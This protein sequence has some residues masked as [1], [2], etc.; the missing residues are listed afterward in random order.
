MTCECAKCVRKLKNVATIFKAKSIEQ[1]KEL[2]DVD[3]PEIFSFCKGNIPTRELNYATDVVLNRKLEE[4]RS[5]RE[6]KSPQ[7]KQESEGKSMDKSMEKSSVKHRTCQLAGQL[8]VPRPPLSHFPREVCKGRDFDA[9]AIGPYF[10]VYSAEGHRS[11]SDVPDAWLDN[12]DNK[13]GTESKLKFNSEMI[14][15]GNVDYCHICKTAGH[16]ILCD[17]CPRGFH[18]DCLRNENQSSPEGDHWECFVCKNEKTETNEHVIDGKESMDLVGPAFLELDITDERALVGLDV[19][20]IIHQMLTNLIHYDFGNVFSKPVDESSVSGYQDIVKCPMDIG[21][22]CSK[23]TNGEFAKLLSEAYTMDDLVTKVLNDIELIWRNCITFNVIGSAVSRMAYVLRRRVKMIYKRSILDRLCDKVITDVKSYAKKFD[24]AWASGL[25]MSFSTEMS[26][27]ST[28][29][30]KLS[31][32]AKL[33]PKSG[34]K[35]MVHATNGKQIAIFDSVCGRV[36]KVYSSVKSASKAV[37]I[38]LKSGYE[39]EWNANASRTDLNLKLIAEKSRNDPNSL[40]FGYRWLFLDDLNDGKVVFWKSICDI[41]EMRYDQCT[42]VFQSV[43]EA[44]SSS[45]LSKTLDV[46]D[47]REKLLRLPRNGDWAEI[48]GLQWRRPSTS[49][50]LRESLECSDYLTETDEGSRLAAEAVINGDNLQSWKN[51]AF[52]KKDLLTNRNLIGFDSIELA[53]RDW[54]QAAM[55]SE[56]F[57]QSEDRSLANFKKFYL[58]GDRNIDGIIWQTVDE[59]NG[60]NQEGKKELT[61]TETIAHRMDLEGGEFSQN[62]LS[63]SKDQEKKDIT[64]ENKESKSRSSINNSSMSSATIWTNTHQQEGLENPFSKIPLEESPNNSRKRK[65]LEGNKIDL[66][67]SKEPRLSVVTVE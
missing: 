34:K 24:E 20:C 11:V 19:L 9:R 18:Q 37:E 62:A 55:I 5:R 41:V 48:D 45:N 27:K 53:H 50:R 51:C 25:T 57:P 58:D 23:L 67:K 36:V 42:L 56:N 35:F 49:N 26:D 31:A 6:E 16:L 47:L 46:N 3:F 33:Q 2:C 22:I 32:I 10:T 29:N 30:W 44:L 54:M 61:K 1:E 12:T 65:F 17:C 15:D 21:T 8:N 14:E 39:C 52:L 64:S 60:V 38:I 28:Y 13:P 63:S 59:D 40:L 43:E 66:P 7:Q 4:I